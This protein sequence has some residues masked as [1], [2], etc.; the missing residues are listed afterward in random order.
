MINSYSPGGCLNWFSGLNWTIFRLWKIKSQKT[1]IRG[2]FFLKW[3]TLFMHYPDPH[4]CPGKT[5]NTIEANPSHCISQTDFNVKIVIINSSSKQIVQLGSGSQMVTARGK[6]WVETRVHNA[7][8]RFDKNGCRMYLLS[9]LKRHRPLNMTAE[10]LQLV[11]RSIYFINKTIIM[12]RRCPRNAIFKNLSKYI[13][14]AFLLP[15]NNLIVYRKS[16]FAPNQT[17]QINHT[18]GACQPPPKGGGP[19]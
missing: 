3:H 5:Y 1:I 18:F 16:G 15:W 10:R 6:V 12:L 14:T 13:P 19:D 7:F 8:Q 17:A 9:I 2:S 11:S 4:A